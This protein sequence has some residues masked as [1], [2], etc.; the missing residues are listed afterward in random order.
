MLR[1]NVPF[2]EIA[3]NQERR[4]FMQQSLLKH[5]LRFGQTL[6]MFGLVF[7]FPNVELKL[8]SNIQRAQT[9]N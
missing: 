7:M 4:F 8:L 9:S 6:R 5:L 3:V 1:L 2:L